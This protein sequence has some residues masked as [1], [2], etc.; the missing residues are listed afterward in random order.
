M[1]VR[2]MIPSFLHSVTR[3]VAEAE[4]PAGLIRDILEGLDLKYPGFKEK[5]A[6]N[7]RIKVFVNIYVN[8]ENIRFLNGEL[9]Q[10]KDG[11]EVT[12][13]PE[14]AGGSNNSLSG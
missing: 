9:T 5:I 2:V 13:I 6:G 3:G 12:I 11:D 8:E 14:V 4:A 10:A 7:G 1:P